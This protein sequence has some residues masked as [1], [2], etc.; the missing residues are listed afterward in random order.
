M[1]PNRRRG[2][3]LTPADSAVATGDGANALEELR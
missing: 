1:M 2:G 3:C